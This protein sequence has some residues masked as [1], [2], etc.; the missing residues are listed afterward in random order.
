MTKEQTVALLTWRAM[1]FTEER[2]FICDGAVSNGVWLFWGREDIAA[3]AADRIRALNTG[4]AAGLVGCGPWV[5]R[6][7]EW[8]RE[9]IASVMDAARGTYHELHDA[10]FQDC[11]DGKRRELFGGYYIND[12][13]WTRAK[14][15][16]W[17]LF[18]MGA[19]DDYRPFLVV[20]GGVAIGVVM[21]CRVQR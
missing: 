10:D 20:D 6:T 15:L 8:A 7:E 18:A 16:G 11:V 5:T 19:A 3:L 2:L 9:S 13:F 17:R 21:P 4:T 1:V 12:D 14:A